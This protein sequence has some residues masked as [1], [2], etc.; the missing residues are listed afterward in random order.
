MNWKIYAVMHTHW[1]KEWY[2]SKQESD[3]LLIKNLEEVEKILT[4][5]KKYHSYTYDGQ[6][7]ILDDYKQYKNI[8]NN[9]TKLLKNKKLIVGPWYTQPDLFNITSESIVRNLQFGINGCEDNDFEYLKT[10]Y[11][12]DSFGH[13]AQLPQ[14]FRQFGLDNFVYWRGISEKQINENG[15]LHFWEGID[16]TKIRAHNLLSGYWGMGSY[17]PYTMNKDSDFDKLAKE[18]LI[19]SKNIID[20]LKNN[21]KNDDM[22]LLLPFGGD[23]APINECTVKFFNAVNKYSKDEYILSD[24]DTYF[25]KIEN[26]NKIKL[27]TIKGELKSPY[28]SRIHKTI[29]SQRYDIKKLL[30]NTEYYLYNG[31]EPLASYWFK[32]G[33]VYPSETINE[34]I[35]M[36][37]ISQSHDSAGGCNSDTTNDDVKNR[38][39]RSSDLINSEINKILKN[40]AEHLKL[41]NEEFIIFNQNFDEAMLE[42]KITLFSKSDNIKIYDDEIEVDYYLDKKI[43]HSGG[44][45]V[46]SANTIENEVN[47]DAFNQFDIILFDKIKPFSFKKYQI[48][49]SEQNSE[50][51]SI[52][53]VNKNNLENNYFDIEITEKGIL[54]V[55]DKKND[56]KYTITI[57]A[58]YDL[59]DSYDFSP[60]KENYNLIN[61]IEKITSKINKT[62]LVQK[63]TSKINFSIDDLY[64]NDSKNQEL[65]LNIKLIE[66][67]Y[68]IDVLMTNVNKQIKWFLSFKMNE[69]VSST[70][71]N[72][73]FHN[74]VRK[75]ICE[76][77]DNWRERNWTE[78]PVPIETNESFVSFKNKNNNLLN[79]FTI[80]NNEYEMNGNDL[81]I[82]LF[83]SVEDLGR[84]NILWRPGRASGTSEMGIK[85]HKATLLNEKLKFSFKINNNSKHNLWKSAQNFIRPILFYQKQNH[86]NLFKKMDR[87]LLIND[88]VCNLNN[89]LNYKLNNDFI[90]TTV[91]KSNYT[92]D[93]IIRGFNS[94][95]KNIKLT[96]KDIE[97]NNLGFKILDLKEKNII[98]DVIHEYNLKMFE[99]ITF[100]IER[101]E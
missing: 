8:S 11:L 64:D 84:H 10:A 7:S 56:E 97:N 17:F 12:P 93:I 24:Y 98:T 43:K 44:R 77:I 73:A 14:I 74:I 90:I 9:M 72:Q 69:E 28:H 15:V 4:K 82:T 96:I 86:N 6:F 75:N 95:D 80:G 22:N 40:A 88:E 38:L 94:S 13:N 34:S 61:T 5:N 91:K 79:I 89:N 65:D 92:N 59:G 25:D 23:Q 1:D 45:K 31:L 39:S 57:D 30:K 20:N 52:E 32:N 85:T 27:K 81:R 53:F 58:I 36:I 19:N 3:V 26:I 67:N 49:N 70:T 66:D 51:N 41:K 42:Y 16:G 21:Y 55:L 47:L 78:K 101:N 68:Y 76:G 18:F 100:S 87:F 99:I 60:D 2:F 62:E 35:K 54:K 48:K 50:Q 29:G 83:R 46:I 63:L 71:A 33:G 37:L